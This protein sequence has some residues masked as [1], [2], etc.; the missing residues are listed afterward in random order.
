MPG[1]CLRSRNLTKQSLVPCARLLQITLSRASDATYGQWPKFL[2]DSL[3]PGSATYAKQSRG[4]ASFLRENTDAH[5]LAAS[6]ATRTELQSFV[7][8]ST[9]EGFRSRCC[10]TT[11]KAGLSSNA[12][13]CG[14]ADRLGTYVQPSRT[15]S[16]ARV[17]RPGKS[18][19]LAHVAS[20][21]WATLVNKIQCRQGLLVGEA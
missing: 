15:L 17:V 4:R 8:R 10:S 2:A 20:S 12:L 6:D 14:T 5:R 19:H 13:S 3:D 11:V 1:H 7:I 16:H 18:V 9:I 21:S